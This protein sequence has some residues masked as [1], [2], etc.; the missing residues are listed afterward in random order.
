MIEAYEHAPHLPTGNG[1]RNCRGRDCNRKIKSA[2]SKGQTR[3]SKQGNN[4]CQG[5]Q[6]KGSF[7]DG[8]EEMIYSWQDGT[9]KLQG[10]NICNIDNNISKNITKKPVW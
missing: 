5:T 9:M 7:E 1:S 3:P 6:G 2:A 8:H 10:W 4:C